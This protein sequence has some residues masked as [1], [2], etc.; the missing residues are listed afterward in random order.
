MSEARRWFDSIQEEIRMDYTDAQTTH[1]EDIQ[2]SGHEG[3]STWADLLAKWLPSNYG[4][5]LRKYIIGSD[6]EVKPSETDIVIFEPSYPQHLRYRAK[7]HAAGVAAA[8]SVKLTARKAHFKEIGAWSKALAQLSHGD[9]K[10]LEGQLLPGFPTGLLAHS[11]D[12]GEDPIAVL[13][14]GLHKESMSADHPKELVD[15]I[16]VANLATLRCYRTSYEQRD[17]PG[18]GEGAYVNT[19][20]LAMDDDKQYGAVAHFIIS[21]YS[22]LGRR[23]PS[24]KKLADGL[25]HVTGTG[26]GAGIGRDWDAADVYS[27]YFLRTAHDLLF[28]HSGPRKL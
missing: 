24:M 27:Q 3:E 8:F 7:V 9:R 19:A 2:R 10:T 21:L 11:H 23:D 28:D 15:L 22:L 17:W 5:G 18:G 6:D 1:K 20:Y 25:A 14:D 26:S 12:L 16:C 13:G 4:V